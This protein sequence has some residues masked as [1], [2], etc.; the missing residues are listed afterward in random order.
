MANSREAQAGSES[1]PH[2]FGRPLNI[3]MEKW[4]RPARVGET[5][6]HWVQG[7]DLNQRPSGYEPDE[8]PGC[9]TLQWKLNDADR[10]QLALNHHIQ[11][12]PPRVEGRR[13]VHVVPGAVNAFLGFFPQFTLASGCSG[14]SLGRL[15][16]RNQPINHYQPTSID[17][18]AAHRPTCVSP[19]T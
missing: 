12:A 13:N 10:K 17:R 8:L 6:L 19:D 16:V 9:S 7:L 11:A 1:Q 15:S 18:K 14:P 2:L 3:C 5:G 4:R